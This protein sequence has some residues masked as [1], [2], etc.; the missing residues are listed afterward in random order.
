[1]HS[2][3]IDSNIQRL[4]LAHVVNGGNFGSPMQTVNIPQGGFIHGPISTSSGLTQIHTAP[5]STTKRDIIVNDAL[6][7]LEQVRIFYTDRPTVYIKFLDVMKEY[8]MNKYVFWICE[9]SRR[10][11]IMKMRKKSMRTE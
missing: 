10:T 7:F 1:M 8:K 3:P 5:P 6:V 11:R 2:G 4:G 9:E